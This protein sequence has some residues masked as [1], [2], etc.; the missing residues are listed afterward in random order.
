MAVMGSADMVPPKI[1][2]PSLQA[3]IAPA[4][5]YRATSAQAAATRARRGSCSNR[6]GNHV[7]IVASA[8]TS[9]NSSHQPPLPMEPNHSEA[10]SV[11]NPSPTSR[12]VKLPLGPPVAQASNHPYWPAGFQSPAP[13]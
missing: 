7:G 9:R 13:S 3:R 1:L 10:N 4:T 2:Y 6:G 11:T 12:H 8:P 5:T